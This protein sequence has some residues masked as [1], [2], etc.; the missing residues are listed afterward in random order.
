MAANRKNRR[1]YPTLQ[2]SESFGIAIESFYAHKVRFLLTAL[3]MVIGTASLIL[4][5]TIGLTGKQYILQQIQAIGTNMMVVTSGVSS[6][7]S[8][9]SARDDLTLNDLTAVRERVPNII[10]ASPKI[11]LHD[12]IALPGG[13]ERD[14]LVLGVAPEYLVVRNLDVLAGRF[15]D[16][17]ETQSRSKVAVI[18]QKMAEMLHGDQDTAVGKEIKINGLPF[19]VIGTFRERVDTFGQTEISDDTIL[20]PYTVARF[21]TNTDAVE[22][23]FFSVADPSDIPGATE[24]IQKVLQSR[25][26]PESVYKVDNLTLLLT[27]ASKI[28]NAL[29]TILLL[30][31]VLTLLVSG[32]GIM[33]I[34]LATVS[35]RIREIGVRK[36]VGATSA[37]IRLEFLTEAIL[38]SLIGGF[39]GIVI[40]MALPISVRLLTSYR[41]PISGLSV[42]I[43]VVVSSLIGVVFG[44][45]PA[46]RAAQLDPVE[47]LR[48]E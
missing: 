19:V 39:V 31:A 24:E 29:T 36:A 8:T 17:R 18:T 34:M 44:T 22:Q 37:A 10:A 2:L 47:S 12:R 28:A 33:N 42:V 16:D 45:M 13:K 38:I 43:A 5:V 6:V 20:I 23:L 35:A 9:E 14:I 40:G 4:V 25:H 30:I 46:A 27:V 21:F 11:E 3:G 7:Y 26:R 41:I 15:F 48:Y 1:A 32:V